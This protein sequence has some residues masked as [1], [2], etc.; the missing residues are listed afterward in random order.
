[1]GQNCCSRSPR[2][3]SLGTCE[4]GSTPDD[5]NAGRRR[6]DYGIHATNPA[7]LL[8]ALA[9]VSRRRE[10]D[11]SSILSEAN[12][13]RR[14]EEIEEEP[15]PTKAQKEKANR[16]NNNEETETTRDEA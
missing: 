1:M 7:E 5:N 14:D 10:E 2:K 9:K 3:K 15:Q 6:S 11:V 16:K 13:P 4:N 8:K 12:K